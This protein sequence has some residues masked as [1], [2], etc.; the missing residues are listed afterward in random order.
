[1]PPIRDLNLAEWREQ[2]QAWRRQH[3]R[4]DPASLPWEARVGS[5]TAKAAYLVAVVG[6]QELPVGAGLLQ[7]VPRIRT[8]L[9]SVPTVGRIEVGL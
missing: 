1:M 9:L 6:S 3:P 4:A 8:L 7:E 5:P 2:A